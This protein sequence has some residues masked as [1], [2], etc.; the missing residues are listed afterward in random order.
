MGGQDPTFF[1]IDQLLRLLAIGAIQAIPLLAV[2]YLH[3]R[4]SKARK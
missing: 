2:A 3:A 4:W 1:A